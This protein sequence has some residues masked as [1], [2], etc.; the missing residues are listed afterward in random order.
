[1]NMFTQK[2]K[3]GGTM[4]LGP[5]LI[6]PSVISAI[7]DIKKSQ[8]TDQSDLECSH[9]SIDDE[10]WFDLSERDKKVVCALV[11]NVYSDYITNMDNYISAMADN[12]I[13]LS[14]GVSGMV[15]PCAEEMYELEDTFIKTFNKNVHSELH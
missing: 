11:A 15:I 9:L 12:G 4:I 3:D 2:C 8:F 5:N 14:V 6:T 13:L 1:M 7:D 10:N